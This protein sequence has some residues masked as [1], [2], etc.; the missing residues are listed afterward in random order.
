MYMYYLICSLTYDTE[1]YK[2]LDQ[3]FGEDVIQQHDAVM[4]YMSSDK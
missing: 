2:T 3:K 1:F 4:T